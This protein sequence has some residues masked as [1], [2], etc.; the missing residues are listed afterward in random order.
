[1]QAVILAGERGAPLYPL[2]A[3]QPRAMLPLA[4][5]PLVQYQLELLKRHG[6]TEALLCLQVMPETFE[7]RFGDGREL[8]MTLRYHRELVP[9]GT[10]GAV[11]SVSDRLIGD[12]VLVLNG[13]VLTDADLSGLI[14]FHEDK[15]AAV[16]MLLARVSDDPSRFGVV[17][18]DADGRVTSFA[19]KPAAGEA[20]ADTVNAGVYVLSR[21]LLRRMPPDTEYSFERQLFPLLLSEGAPVYGVVN[22]GKYWLPVSGLPDYQRGISDI[23][24]RRVDVEIKGGPLRE[25][26]WV[27][28]G[29]S[30]HPTADLRGRV[31]VNHHTEIGR[32]AR[33][34]GVCSIGSRCRIGEGALVEDSVIWRG[35]VVEPGAVVRGSILGEN[36][37][38]RAG[39]VVQPGTVVGADGIIA[40]V[41]AKLPTRGDI[42]RASIKFG[43][44]GWRGVLADD[45][46]VDNVRLV[47]QAIC[48]RLRAAGAPG[49]GLVVGYDGRAQSDEFAAAVAGVA[50]AN[51]LAVRL[52]DK[53]IP[54]PALS[55][56]C[57]YFAAA[58]GG[59]GHRLGPRGALLRHQDEDTPGRPGSGRGGGARRGAAT[60][61]P[62]F[63][64]R[65]AYR[66]SGAAPF[67][68]HG[69]IPRALR[70]P[71]GHRPHPRRRPERSGG[72]D[73][74][75]GRRDTYRHT[76]VRRSFRRGVPVRK[77]PDLRGRHPRGDGGEPGPA[78]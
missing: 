65:P 35:T 23:L 48:D 28:E 17:T 58:G 60:R 2:T 3:R 69:A 37:V 32:E 10:A 14:A 9:L 76:G 1:M 64:R 44:D 55:F 31:F 63:R 30:V 16:T 36:C 8:G 7:E 25:G 27:G 22:E 75:F 67:G 15:Q 18:C 41:V 77:E 70:P 72:C 66:G 57:R 39:A 71:R 51:G 73:A 33:I 52:S 43:A 6:I 4:G 38:V 74:R 50:A 53:P 5:T 29:A 47:A 56:A 59:D 62:P 12:S 20:A 49:E 42:R 19:E 13:H 54:A 68:H 45:F 34:R 40:S 61:E 46:T 24:E 21:S 11:R 78:L 26:V